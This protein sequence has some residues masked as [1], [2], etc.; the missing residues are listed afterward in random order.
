MTKV[1]REFSFEAAHMLS[2]YS[3]QCKN[4]HGHSYKLQVSVEGSPKNRPGEDDSE[5]VMDFSDLKRI[6]DERV[7][8]KVDHAIIF[9][10]FEYRGDAEEELLKWA[11]KYGLKHVA[12]NGRCTAETIAAW[13]RSQI[14]RKIGGDVHVRLWETEKSFTEV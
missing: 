9:S 13:I 4:L 11:Q 3:G 2:G 7:V 5:M 6:V 8:S 1:T 14:L 10:S 12:L